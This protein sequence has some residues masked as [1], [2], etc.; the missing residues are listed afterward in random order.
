[1]N[2][3]LPPTPGPPAFITTGEFCHLTGI[4]QTTVK[5]MC[6]RGEVAHIV[7]SERGDRRIPYREVERLLAEAEATRIGSR[8]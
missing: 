1:M 2:S 6:D 4:S 3:H 8:P 7:I 5:R